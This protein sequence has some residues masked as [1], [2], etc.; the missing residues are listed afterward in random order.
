MERG[1]GERDRGSTGEALP[2]ENAEKDVPQ[3]RRR[4]DY[5]REGVFLPDPA[6]WGW[7]LP[8][9]RLFSGKRD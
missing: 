1:R 8:E 3:N 4:I 6:S 2:G 7:T 5:L 9:S